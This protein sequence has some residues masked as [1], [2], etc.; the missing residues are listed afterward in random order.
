MQYVL[1]VSTAFIIGFIAAIPV[2][3][4]QVEVARRAINGYFI[5]AILVVAGGTVSDLLYGGIAFFGVRSFL[6]DP[7]TEAIFWLVNAALLIGLGIYTI[8][9]SR[10]AQGKDEKARRSLK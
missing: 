4:S 8:R 10:V 1:F 3:A 5:S 7:V 9:H 2:S 6:H